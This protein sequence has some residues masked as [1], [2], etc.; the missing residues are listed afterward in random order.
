[1]CALSSGFRIMVCPVPGDNTTEAATT[2]E[3]IAV[4]KRCAY[5]LLDVSMDG[6]KAGWM[7][8]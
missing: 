2:T 5:C 7:N 6:L 4:H 1:M 8:G 3:Y